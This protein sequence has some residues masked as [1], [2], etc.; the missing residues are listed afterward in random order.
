MQKRGQKLSKPH[1]Q[2]AF[3]EKG[4]RDFKASQEENLAIL[5]WVKYM[6]TKLKLSS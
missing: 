6:K 1:P 5:G 2:S 3:I 4:K